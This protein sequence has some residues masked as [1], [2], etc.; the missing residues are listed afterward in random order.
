MEK[1]K[2]NSYRRRG[3]ANGRLFDDLLPCPVAHR[4]NF[5]SKDYFNG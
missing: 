5:L 4:I 3:T 2:G 1:H